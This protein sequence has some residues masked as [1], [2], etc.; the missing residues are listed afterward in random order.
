MLLS[1]PNHPLPKRSSS[2]E[3]FEGHTPP[4]PPG[5]DFQWLSTAHKYTHRELW[6]P[7]I[8]RPITRRRV[9][10]G[11]LT[12]RRTNAEG[13]DDKTRQD[14]DRERE[15]TMRREETVQVVGRKTMQG[16]S[17][18]SIIK[19][20]KLYSFVCHDAPMLLLPRW[21]NIKQTAENRVNWYIIIKLQN[22]CFCH[23]GIWGNYRKMTHWNYDWITIL[24]VLA[25]LEYVVTIV[26]YIF[27]IF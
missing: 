19:S 5:G 15:T 7:L 22:G 6:P 1:P 24:F 2:R 25:I 16:R 4:I 20:G 18:E 12:A 17:W 27:L 3:P 13:W 11:F 23:S 9:L 21:W 8:G 10:L 26:S 14:T